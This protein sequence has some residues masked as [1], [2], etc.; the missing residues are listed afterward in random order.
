MPSLNM[1][2]IQCPRPVSLAEKLSLRTS[3]HTGVAIRLLIR[4]KTRLRE[5]RSRSRRQQ[6]KKCTV[7]PLADGGP[8]L[9][10]S[11]HNKTDGTPPSEPYGFVMSHQQENRFILPSPIF[12]VGNSVT[13]QKEKGKEK[14]ACCKNNTPNE[15]RLAAR[16][17]PDGMN[18]AAHMNC[19]AEH[20]GAIQIMCEAQIRS[21]SEKS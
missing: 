9:P 6:Y 15:L 2:E 7:M 16:E 4:K 10:T 13:R 20:Q 14:W 8:D 17:L 19:S 18:C 11:R 12:F 5:K 21:R 1:R 3:A